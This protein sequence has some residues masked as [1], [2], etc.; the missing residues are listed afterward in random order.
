MITLIGR[1]GVITAIWNV[2]QSRYICCGLYIGKTDKKTSMMVSCRSKTMSLTAV[3]F[4]CG[5]MKSETPFCVGDKFTY[6][7]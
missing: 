5:Q 2:N 1:C 3:L 4:P 7:D 6:H